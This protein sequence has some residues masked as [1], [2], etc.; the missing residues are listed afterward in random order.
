MLHLAIKFILCPSYSATWG[1]E[2]EARL[3][4]CTRVSHSLMEGTDPNVILRKLQVG[5]WGGALNNE[6]KSAVDF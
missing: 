2:N 4:A 3:S 6:C 5:T 1:I